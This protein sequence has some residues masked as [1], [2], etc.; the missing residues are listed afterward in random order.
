MEGCPECDTNKDGQ[1]SDQE[2]LHRDV[3]NAAPVKGLTMS[4]RWTEL[5]VPNLLKVQHGVG[6]ARANQAVEDEA[7][8]FRIHDMAVIPPG[9]NTATV[10][11]NGWKL[12]YRNGE[13]KVQG[14]GNVISNILQ[15][16]NDKKQELH[17]QAGGVLSDNDGNDPYE[18]CYI[19]TL[20][21]WHRNPHDFQTLPPQ[22]AAWPVD[23]DAD[24]DQLT[25]LHTTDVDASDDTAR[26]LHGAVAVDDPGALLPR[27]FTLMYQTPDD[28]HILQAGFDLGE[29]VLDGASIG[30]TSNTLWKD[31]S[32]Y[33][34]YRG[35]ELVSVLSG[36]GVQMW[37]PDTVLRCV[38]AVNCEEVHNTV[39]LTPNNDP[40]TFPERCVGENSGT[41]PADN[42]PIQFKVENVPFPY[43]VPVLTG[44]QLEYPC[45]DHQVEN[46][47][48]YLVGFHYD[49]Q[50]RT[51]F[52]TIVS[53]L[54]DE[55]FWGGQ[56]TGEAQYAVSILGLNASAL[57]PTP[58]TGSTGPSA[59]LAAPAP[60][61][62]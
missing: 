52:Y 25:F 7:L 57:P 49:N 56:H 47:G 60:Y 13:H 16:Q 37:H 42:H 10:F 59:I 38:D 3:L 26:L 5:E 32:N 35:A 29:P 58:Q 48:V 54:D 21:F 23:S 17:W 12:A 51:L 46:I 9:Y 28:H 45:S 33:K 34:D 27:G 1:I 31:N 44:W 14:F 62:P 24:P 2:N 41:V 36:P 11:L 18:W 55:A 40:A 50:T 53:T 15:V 4:Q 22:I 30:W 39:P 20:L 8:G 19:Y 6:C 43:A 61:L